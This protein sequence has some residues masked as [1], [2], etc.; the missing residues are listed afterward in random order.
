MYGGSGRHTT[1]PHIGL[2]GCHSLYGAKRRNDT[3]GLLPLLED[4]Q[5]HGLHCSVQHC[6]YSDTHLAPGWFPTACIV[7]LQLPAQSCHNISWP[8]PTF[9]WPSLQ[10]ASLAPLLEEWSLQLASGSPYVRHLVEVW[11]CLCQ[12]LFG[13][14]V[15]LSQWKWLQEWLSWIQHFSY[16]GPP[17]GWKGPFGCQICWV[18][19]EVYVWPH[20]G[21]GILSL[22]SSSAPLAFCYPPSPAA[23]LSSSCPTAIAWTQCRFCLSKFSSTSETSPWTPPVFQCVSSSLSLGRTGDS[24]ITLAYFLV[25]VGVP[26]IQ[27]PL[28]S[29][30]AMGKI[31]AHPH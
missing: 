11:S 3:Y 31:R 28:V 20:L 13:L 9:L 12:C 18:L 5:P 23:C 25:L 29:H 22:A 19:Q 17:L 4:Y 30:L 6:C 8:S 7:S 21:V 26:A 16:W 27:N 14:S 15:T 1:V 24:A 10:S 2:S